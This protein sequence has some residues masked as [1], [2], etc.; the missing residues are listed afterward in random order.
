MDEET[1]SNVDLVCALCDNGGEIASCEGRCLRSFHATKDSGEGCA[2]LG[3]SRQQFNAIKVFMCKN[4]EYERYQCFACGC[5]GSAKTDPPEVFPCASATCGYF[6]HAKCAAQ[7]LFPENEAKATEYTAKIA[8]GA[9][10]ACP[11]HKCDICKY[12]EN[13]EDKELQFAVCR[14][15]PKAYHRRCLPRKI[16]FNDFTENGQCVFQRAWD[17]L[18]PN[19]RIL[20]Y[21]LKHDIDL[22]YRTPT[23]NHIKFPENPASMKKPPSIK[24]PLNSVNG[25]NK[26]IVKIR[27]IDEL[28]SAPL[29]NGKRSSG[30]VKHSSMSNLMNKRR[31]VPVSEEISVVMEKPVVMSKL[32][33]SSFPEIDRYTEMRIFEFAQKT[34]AAITMEDVQKK[35]VVPSTHTPNLQNTDKITL[36]KVERSVEAVKAA[37]HMLENG[38]CIEEAK[39]VCSPSDLFQIAKWKNKLNIFLAPFLHGM[40]Y[41]SYGRHF[42]KVDKL[43]LIVDKLQWYIQSGDTVVDFCCGSNDFS[44][45]LKEKLEASG[46]NCFY[47][48]FDLIQPKND[49]SFERRDWM[50]VQPDELPTG[51]RLIMGLNPPFGFKASLANQFINKALTFKPKLIIL[52]VPKETERLDKKYPPYELIWQDSQQL[53]GKSFYLP[54]SLDSDN[55]VM[56]QWNMSAPPLSLWSRS[57][58]AKRHSEI[59]KSMRHLPSENAFSGD[60]QRVA[61]GSSVPTAGHVEMDDAEGEEIPSSLLDKLLSDAYH[62]P[63]SAPG[64]YWNDTNGRSRQPCNYETPGRSDPTYVYHTEMGVGSDM[65][66]SFSETDCERQDQVSSISKHGGIDSQACNA[67]ESALAEEPAAAADCERQDEA[68]SISKHGGTDSQACNAVESELAEVPAAAADCDEVTSAAG[69]YHL[70]E[71]SSHV[72]RHAAGVQ[73]WRVEDSPILEEGEL[74]DAPPVAVGRPAAGTQ[75]LTEDW[76]ILEEGELSDAPPVGRPAAGT[77][78]LTEDTPPEVTL[79]ADSRCGQ[80]MTPETDSQCGQPMTPEADSRCGQPVTPEA[81]QPDGLRHAARH[82]ARTLPPRNTFPGLRFRQGCNTSRQFLSQGMGHPAVHPGLSNGWI[83]DDDY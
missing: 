30:I 42:T 37:L 45:L 60:W 48:N 28:P 43:Q 66:I 73:Y 33:F 51:C 29:P 15:C 14:R 3:Y 82:N 44:L 22:K 32:P 1:Y 2:T 49:F 4:C 17:D 67:V 81:G 59:A 36:G 53:L 47:K 23:R 74:S 56:E 21:C 50:T 27:R 9:K 20:I 64:D 8:D 18:L 10:F 80:L 19:N 25:M 7:L 46:K 68:S 63:T 38:A 65:S 11:L 41:T 75:Q 24:K 16:A 26:K 5:L 55:K 57:D 61:D 78:Q 35:L 76:P 31:K 72:G 34:S 52:I 69:P 54:G 39:S 83:E 40:R 77:Q 70:L 6:Y 13:K 12:G 62:D 79:E 58:W 71:D